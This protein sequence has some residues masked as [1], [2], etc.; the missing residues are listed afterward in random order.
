MLPF[1]DHG[2]ISRRLE[3]TRSLLA[4]T[5][6]FSVNRT[7]VVLG[8]LASFAVPLVLGRRLCSESVRRPP[9]S[10]RPLRR[11]KARRHSNP[12]A[13]R[14]PH[15]DSTPDESVWLTAKSRLSR[16]PSTAY[17][18]PFTPSTAL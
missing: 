1:H 9:K 12:R 14:L 3:L 13:P 8:R 7:I 16:H 4:P 17:R 5:I 11:S 2:E 15:T 18:W 10:P 6:E